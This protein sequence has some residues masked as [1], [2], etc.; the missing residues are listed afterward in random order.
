MTHT[1]KY[2][3]HEGPTNRNEP[4]RSLSSGDDDTAET[5]S[6]GE[7]WRAMAWWKEAV[8]E[9]P[10]DSVAGIVRESLADSRESG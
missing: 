3:G 7:L 5:L 10:L 6:C 1:I 2:P 4:K 8:G 9:D